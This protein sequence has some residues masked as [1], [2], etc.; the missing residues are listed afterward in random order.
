MPGAKNARRTGIATRWGGGGAFQALGRYGRQTVLLDGSGGRG[1]AVQGEA[2]MGH[3]LR[4]LATH[5]CRSGVSRDRVASEGTRSR[6]TSL[7]PRS[8]RRLGRMRGAGTR[9][10]RVFRPPAPHPCRSGASRGRVASEGARSRLAS[11]LQ[12]GCTNHSTRA[13]RR[14]RRERCMRCVCIAQ[15]KERVPWNALFGAETA[16]LSMARSCASSPEPTSCRVPTSVSAWMDL[17]HSTS[18]FL[19]ARSQNLPTPGGAV[20]GRMPSP[21]TYNHL[22]G[23]TCYRKRTRSPLYWSPSD[24]W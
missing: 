17:V 14:L 19:G 16:V 8:R 21:L 15:K 5:P 11:L 20:K 10:R 1:I 4:P 6:L 22:S 9:T 13:V 3:L 7:L 24:F 2:G 23:S 18:Q 12:E